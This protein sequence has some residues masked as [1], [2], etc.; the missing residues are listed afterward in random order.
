[1]R[2]ALAFFCLSLLLGLVGCTN[3]NGNAKKVP[4]PA[5]R[6]ADAEAA[7]RAPGERFTTFPAV[8]LHGLGGEERELFA[9]I[10]NEE[11]CPCDCP[12]SF[13]GCLQ[14]G[15]RCEPAVLLGNWIAEQLR[16]GMA[17]DA[18]AEQAAREIAGGFAA[19]PK[20]IDLAG[21]AAKGKDGAPYTIVEYADFE[22]PH[23]RLASAVVDRLVKANP[24]KVRVVYK[25]FPLT[26]HAMARRAAAASEAAGQQGRFWEMHDAIF[27]TQTMLDDDLILGHAKALGLDVARFERDWNDPATAAK[28]DASRKEGEALGVD[29]TPAFFVN[30]RPFHL[31]RTPEAF[32]LR[33]QMEDARKSS[34]CE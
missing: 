24:G 23:C 18:L 26:F 27:A 8:D 22:C 14:E 7:P 12:K 10:A 32:G 2:A 34:S 1:M 17:P 9:R 13:G 31:M 25:H 30:G 33:L 16:D 15:S 11:I 6:P 4:A 5:A 29:S 21:Y 3:G 19:K 20:V 28:V